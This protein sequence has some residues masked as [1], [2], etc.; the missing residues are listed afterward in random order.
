[1]SDRHAERGDPNI[2][3][4]EAV[5]IERLMNLRQH[6]RDGKRSPHKPLL[7]LLA[8]A[9][10]DA[11]GSSAIPWVEAREQLGNLL[12]EFGPT[13]TANAAQSA[14]YPFTQLRSDD[15]WV[16]DEDVP[17]DRIGPLERHHVTGRFVASVED[18]MKDS[19]VLY[20]TARALVEAEFPPSIASDVLAAVGFDPSEIYGNPGAVVSA[21]THTTHA[22]R[23]S[24]HWPGRILAAWDRQCAFCGFDGQLGFGSV[25]LEAAHVRWFTYDGPDSLDNGVALCALHHKLF[26]RGALGLTEDYRIV[27]SDQFTARTEAGR[28]VYELADRALRPRPGTRL[29][30]PAH[31]DWHTTQV[32][33]G[34]VVAD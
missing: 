31:L 17:M 24:A 6:Q 8:L 15:L 20:A 18:A 5:V 27:V 28:R 3:V 33:K 10:I 26:D 13:S 11:V 4:E 1:M 16:L 9:R 32:F 14:A 2:S 22:R 30:A 34:R 23:R 19:Q 25:G 7:A 29:P 21:G 12:I